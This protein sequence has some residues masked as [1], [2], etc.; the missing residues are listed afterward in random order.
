MQITTPFKSTGRFIDDWLI[1]ERAKDHPWSVRKAR[2]LVYIHLLLFFSA[3]IFYLANTLIF[4]EMET[5]PLGWAM[6]VA[7][8]LILIFKKWGSF[9]LSGN[10]LSLITF[11]GWFSITFDSGGLYSDNLQWMLVSPLLALLFSS[12][13]SG[14]FWLGALLAASTYL[15]LAHA[16]TK[17]DFISQMEQYSPFY[18]YTSYAGLFVVLVFIVVIFAVGQKQIIA[19]ILEK[20][21]ELARQ[22]AELSEQTRLLQEAERKLLAINKELEQ[23]AYAASHD[24]KEPL[25]MIGSYTQ[26]IRRRLDMSTDPTTTE[27]FGY[28]TDGV[29]R[30]EKLLNDL[31]EYSR[32]GRRP[33]KLADI[34][35]NHTVMIVIGNMMTTME[36]TNTSLSSSKLPVI[37]ATSTEMMQ[38]FQNLISNSIKFRRPDVAPKID[39]RYSTDKK[40]HIFSF[41]DNGIGIPEEYQQSVFNLFERLHSRSDYEG[42]GIGLATCKKIVNN[43]GGNIWVEKS[44][45]SGTEF[46]FT[47]PSHSRT[48]G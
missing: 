34:D 2:T 28:V 11:L 19:A 12:V 42:T 6:L 47:I 45:G 37:K 4:H 15:Y 3:F 18:Y 23:F 20:Q 27:F 17:M 29:Y 26:L 8:M 22:K 41:Q 21:E 40:H 24:L 48:A 13:Y 14:M 31:L 38:L 10:L 1:P 33:E 7:V 9:H 44:N 43:M 32:L 36:A 39:I 46:V 25:R 16:Q 5:P 30:M 35:L